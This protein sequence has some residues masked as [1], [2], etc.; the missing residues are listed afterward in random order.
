MGNKDSVFF[1]NTLKQTNKQNT[2]LEVLSRSILFAICLEDLWPQPGVETKKRVCIFDISRIK[3][4][5]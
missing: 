3:M 1:F 5:E 2:Y 4:R